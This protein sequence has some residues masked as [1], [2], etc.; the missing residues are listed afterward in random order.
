MVSIVQKFDLEM[1]DPSYTLEFRQSLTIKPKDFFI[2]PSLRT[3]Q[4]CW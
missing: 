3:S 4:A 2:R 1:V